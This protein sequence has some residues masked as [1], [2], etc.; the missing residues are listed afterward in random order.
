MTVYSCK[1]FM[2]S[3]TPS[4]RTRAHSELRRRRTVAGDALDYARRQEAIRVR[5][6]GDDQSVHAQGVPPAVLD[7]PQHV[8]SRLH[9]LL[10]ATHLHE[11]RADWPREEEG[12]LRGQRHQGAY[13]CP[14][15]PLC[16]HGDKE[17]ALA[18]HIRSHVWPQTA[19]T[20]TLHHS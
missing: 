18:Q 2:T 15:N 4:Q 20:S 9:L 14:A 16:R 6:E 5:H 13:E 10:R 3:D 8:V 7:A 12:R 1:E 19:P 17:S 11:S